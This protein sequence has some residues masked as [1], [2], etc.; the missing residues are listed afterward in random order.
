MIGPA[1]ATTSKKDRQR[2]LGARA[3]AG[4]F[5]S[6]T[7]SKGR[8]KSLPEGKAKSDAALQHLASVVVKQQQTLQAMQKTPAGLAMYRGRS[9]LGDLGDGI[10]QSIRSIR[11]L[12]NTEV[13]C[14]QAAGANITPTTT[15]TIADFLSGI[16]QGVTDITRVGDSLKVLRLTMNYQFSMNNTAAATQFCWVA[17]IRANDE[18][19]TAAQLNTLDGNAYA[20]LGDLAWDYKDQY[21]VLW[22]KR[23][24]VDPEHQSLIGRVDL[25]LNDHAQYNAGGNTLNSGSIFMAIWSNSTTNN[26]DFGYVFQVE[27]VDN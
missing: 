26:P 25:K 21:R 22:Q 11:R 3:P 12:L 18:I 1:N 24:E 27:F 6:A 23:L 20:Y 10:D 13:K 19:M 4:G 2:F 16:A 15:G 5:P 8:G 17:I 9:D 7:P 14:F